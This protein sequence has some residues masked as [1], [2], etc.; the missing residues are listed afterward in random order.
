MNRRIEWQCLVLSSQENFFDKFVLGERITRKFIAIFAF[1]LISSSFRVAV[2]HYHWNIFRDDWQILYGNWQI[3]PS[4]VVLCTNYAGKYAKTITSRW[5]GR[6]VML[7]EIFARPN[8]LPLELL[9]VDSLPMVTLL[10]GKIWQIWLCCPDLQYTS[11]FEQKTRKMARSYE[12]NS[13]TQENTWLR[14]CR[15]KCSLHVLRNL[16]TSRS[17]K[18]A[19]VQQFLSFSA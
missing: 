16:Q 15:V 11:N 1:L 12:P 8:L 3:T 4:A 2:K 9:F 5:N 18:P 19:R 13:S 14:F 10:P 17:C 7:R 6:G